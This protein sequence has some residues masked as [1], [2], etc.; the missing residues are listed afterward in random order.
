MVYVYGDR[1]L[2]S[3]RT[4]RGDWLLVA[5]RRGWEGMRA[6]LQSPSAVFAIVMW[7]P[8]VTASDIDMFDPGRC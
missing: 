1:W 6:V 4:E 7:A 5:C 2:S 8:E 3:G